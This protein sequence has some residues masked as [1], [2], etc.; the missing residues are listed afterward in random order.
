MNEKALA[1]ARIAAARRNGWE[2]LE[3]VRLRPRGHGWLVDA[4][5]D[6]IYAP[7]QGRNVRASD[8]LAGQRD[9]D[10]APPPAKAWAQTL[11][12]VTACASA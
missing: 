11:P 2:E 4:E 5:T 1:Q 8:H 10:H 6:L 3:A 7:P 12:S 9:H